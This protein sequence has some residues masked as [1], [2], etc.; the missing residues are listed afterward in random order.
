ME[1]VVACTCGNVLPVSEAMAG[2][3]LT[4]SCGRTVPVPSLSESPAQASAEAVPASVPAAE[5]PEQTPPG[6]GPLT[7][8]IAPV[9]AFLRTAGGDRPGRRIPVMVALTPEGIWI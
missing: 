5:P 8:I 4:C 9:Q 3:S 7:E 1:Y 2:S 6:P